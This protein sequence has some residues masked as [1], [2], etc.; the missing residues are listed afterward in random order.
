MS[1]PCAA[2]ASSHGIQLCDAC[3]CNVYHG[4]VRGRVRESQIRT[5]SYDIIYMSAAPTAATNCPPGDF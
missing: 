4:T 1:L 5:L 2:L 3:N